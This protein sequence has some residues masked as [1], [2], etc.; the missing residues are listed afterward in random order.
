MNLPRNG[1]N[2]YP[3][4]DRMKINPMTT[5]ELNQ[6]IAYYK[7]MRIN[8]D[9]TLPLTKGPVRFGMLKRN[10]LS[11][12]SWIVWTREAGDVYI[13]CRDHMTDQKI[14]LHQSG[15]Q[16]IAFTSESGIETVPGSRYVD[17]W[18]EPEHTSDSKV[19]PTFMLFFPSW[20][21]NLTQAIRDENLRVW[22]RNQVFIEAAESP[23]ATIVSFIITD[24]DLT[25]RFNAE[26]ES[27][28]L[29]LG[30]LPA[31]S[32]K[33]LWVVASYV[34]EGNMMSLAEQV[35]D[36]FNT[37]VKEDVKDKVRDL[38][39]GHVLGMCATGRSASGGAFM[40][41]F[42]VEMHWGDRG[43]ATESALARPQLDPDDAH[44]S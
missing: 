2:Y 28:S 16:Q 15:K 29:P 38:P 5:R 24:D 44:L 21:L 12:N 25:M 11:S 4:L 22:N 27:P 39:S 34:P 19:T 23:I 26:G 10:D 40:M 13:S 43:S 32:G 35:M 42:S 36:N 30:I 14:S 33:K 31:R 9:L 17:Q 18:W 8:P 1:D 7:N 3:N 20:A 6:G 41:P 37:S